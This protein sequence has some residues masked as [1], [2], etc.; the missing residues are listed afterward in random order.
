MKNHLT[1]VTIFFLVMFLV[2]SVINV[3]V[4]AQKKFEGY[5]E[6]ITNSKSTMPM[7]PK[8]DNEKQKSFYKPGK[9]KNL[10][11]TDNKTMIFRFDKGL[12]WDI[13][14]N[15]KTYYEMTFEQMQ[16]GMKNAKNKMAEAMKDLGPKEREMMKKM[17]GSSAGAMFGDGD[18]PLISFKITGKKKTIKGYN[19]TLVLMYLGK[20]P[21]ME[22]WMTNKYNIG[23]DLIKIYQKMGVIKGNIPKN[24]KLKGFPILTKMTINMGMGKMEE[25]TTVTKIVKTSVS[26]N[27]F[28]LPKGYKRL[29]NK[30]DF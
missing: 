25:E 27:E 5:W 10:N 14:H 15:D 12:T 13:N 21:M 20:E 7:A 23:D 3:N 24:S 4:F 18:T 11:L 17:M 28:E 30:M 6:S 9:M 1:K 8:K 26:D 2:I 19:C 29:E 16:A 22:M